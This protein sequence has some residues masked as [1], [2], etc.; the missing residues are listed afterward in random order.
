MQ[1]SRAVLAV[2]RGERRCASRRPCHTIR[3]TYVPVQG[4]AEVEWVDAEDPLFL[5]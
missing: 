4:E 2:R 1:V 5:L 3:G